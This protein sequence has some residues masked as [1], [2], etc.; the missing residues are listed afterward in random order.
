[1]EET[2]AALSQVV[3][4]IAALLGIGGGGAYVYTRRKNGHAVIPST[5]H[6]ESLDALRAIRKQL[7]NNGN[8]I[9]GEIQDLGK[10]M[11]TQHESMLDT[12]APRKRVG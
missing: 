2:L 6:E 5:A 7:E 3:V 12:L 1:M 10:S 9:T 11:R 4:A 8:N